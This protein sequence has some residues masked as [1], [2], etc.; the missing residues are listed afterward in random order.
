MIL[1][2]LS[3]W[4]GEKSFPMWSPRKS[5]FIKS[6]GGCSG[7]GLKK[8]YRI[9]CSHCESSSGRGISNVMRDRWRCCNSWAGIGRFSLSWPFF[10][11]VFILCKG[12]TLHWSQSY[13][14]ASFSDLPRKRFP[15]VSFHRIGCLRRPY[16]SFSG[17]WIRQI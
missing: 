3:S 9:D 5:P 17:G 2:Q 6:M 1:E 4:T 16:F 8:A 15:T 7:T 12:N 13:R 11:Q 10:C 14:G